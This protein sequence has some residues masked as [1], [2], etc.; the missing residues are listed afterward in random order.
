[1]LRGRDLVGRARDQR[2]KAFA[3]EP[4]YLDAKTLG[5]RVEEP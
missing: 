2:G 4:T 5:L 1:M 3:R